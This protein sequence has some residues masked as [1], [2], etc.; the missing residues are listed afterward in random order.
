MPLHR[1]VI[2]QSEQFDRVPEL[3]HHF[4]QTFAEEADCNHTCNEY[5]GSVNHGNGNEQQAH[6]N[7]FES[8]GCAT[9]ASARPTVGTAVTARAEGM[10]FEQRL[11]VPTPPP[12]ALRRR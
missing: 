4:G 12:V 7:G 5:F 2:P 11:I 9:R 6:T 3:F 10:W 8:S 1:V